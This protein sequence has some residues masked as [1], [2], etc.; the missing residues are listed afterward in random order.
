M[1]SDM[2]SIPSKSPTEIEGDGDYQAAL[3]EGWLP[4]R[5]VAR[6]TGVNAVTLRA[7]ERRYG[8]IIPKRTP[9]GHRLYG[10]SHIERIK[11]ILAW[12]N[13]GVAVGQVKALLDSQRPLSSLNDTPWVALRQEMLDAVRELAGRRLDEAYNRTA[14]LYPP[15]VLCEQLLMPL[16]EHLE[17]HRKAPLIGSLEQSFFLSW[18]RSKLGA[19][20]YHN[21]Y[22]LKGQSV[23]LA[24]LAETPMNAGL[25]LSAWLLSNAD[26]PIETLEWP[27]AL[28]AYA[29]AAERMSPRCLVLYLNAPLESQQ[30]QQLRR[31]AETCPAPV[32]IAGPAAKLL[33]DVSKTALNVAYDPLDVFSRL[34]ALGLM[35]EHV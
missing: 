7:W 32:I 11:N 33:D 35:A 5:E 29:L 17:Q 28:D 4:I 10:E 1:P 31:L 27:L 20:I 3:N 16:V 25:W 23:L 34:Q 13:R 2:Q 12:I 15:R 14:A 19:R 26:C 22:Q 21:N 6:R 18:L 24:S 30:I 9:K 8:L